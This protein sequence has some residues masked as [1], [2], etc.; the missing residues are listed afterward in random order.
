VAEL[1]R[2]NAPPAPN[3]PIAPVQYSGQHFNILNN[4]FRLYFN[5]LSEALKGLFN[6]NGGKYISFPHIAASDST[7]QYATG[8]NVP[9]IVKWDNLE[10]GSGFTLNPNN[11]ATTSAAGIYKITY[12]VQLANN[13]NTAHD[14]T[15]WIRVNGNTPADDVANSATVFT[16][17]ARKSAGVPSFVCGYSEVVFRL[18]S[19]DSVGLWWGTD[20]AASSGGTAGVYIETI[21]ASTVPLVH[22]AVPSVIGSITFV[23]SVA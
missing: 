19:G 10:Y 1:R 6:N 2:L 21:P 13:N 18:N 4:V 5:R 17:P 20:R 22:P 12:S 3:L 15:F 23:S 11:T 8:N 7:D 9:T 14:A 16:V